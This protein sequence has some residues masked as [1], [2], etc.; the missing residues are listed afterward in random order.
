LL[1]GLDIIKD[2]IWNLRMASPR[3]H[4]APVML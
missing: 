1:L 4:K 2:I 3:N